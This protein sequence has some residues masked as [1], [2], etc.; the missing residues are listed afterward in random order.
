MCAVIGLV[1]ALKIYRDWKRTENQLGIV[2]TEKRKLE[3]DYLKAQT[4]PHFL[5]NTLNSIYYDV[6]NNS[7]ESANSII[8]LSELMRF[9]LHE[10][11]EDFIPVETEIQL[12]DNY[13][14]L[15]KRRYK[16][17]LSVHFQA[18]GDTQQFIPPLICFT[19]I[20]NAFKHGMSESIGHCTIE[21]SLRVNDESCFLRIKNPVS[22]LIEIHP[23]DRPKGLGLKNVRRQLTLIYDE[24]YSLNNVTQ[25][26]S[27]ICTLKIPLRDS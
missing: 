17:S 6:V 3:L 18:E 25:D 7:E 1:S 19:L 10:G 13:I 12:I 21:I 15:Q 20:E 24:N 11:K 27:Y 14:E 4:N 5:F 23:P 8:R 2:Q 9:V 26:E 16:N 22:E